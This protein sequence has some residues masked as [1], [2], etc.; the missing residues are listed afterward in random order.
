MIRALI[1]LE[2]VLLVIL[3]LDR[4]VGVPASGVDI[5][6]AAREREISRH[7]GGNVQEGS[8]R[9]AIA[10]A[11]AARRPDFPESLSLNGTAYAMPRA[12]PAESS[13]VSTASQTPLPATT[14]ADAGS[15]RIGPWQE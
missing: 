7:V 3:A 1:V 9:A 5:D 8:I 14:H 11:A 12:K 6:R 15:R 2:C 4:V 13:T 10:S